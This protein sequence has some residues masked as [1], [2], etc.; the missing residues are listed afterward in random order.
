MSHLLS[1]RDFLK[2]T[3]GVL[4]TLT[5]PFDS[6]GQRRGRTWSLPLPPDDIASRAGQS[7]GRVTASRIHLHA[8]P[9]PTSEISGYRSFDELITLYSTV[10]GP[11]EMAHNT[12]WFKTE[13]GYA[14]SS[15]VQP[16][17]RQLNRPLMPSRVSEDQP[18]LLEV[19]M[20]Y[21]DV[22]RHATTTAPRVYR[23]YYATTHWAVAVERDEA[24]NSWYELRND[25]GHGHYF[26]RAEHLRPISLDELAPISPDAPDKRIE[27][28]LSAQSLTAYEGDEV[29]L[30]ARVSTGAVFSSADGA[31][32]DYRTPKGT[33]HVLR[34]RASRHMQGG[35]PGVDYFD[36]PGIPWVTYF[37][38]SGVA[39]H[40]TYW[41]NDYGRPRSHGCVNMTPEQTRWL[42]LWTE[43]A[44]PAGEE[45]LDAETETGTPI[46]VLQ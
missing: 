17:S 22:R 7:L 1:R 28:K 5:L 37:T 20:P 18:I 6:L 42:F 12:V 39:L 21:T 35:T 23:L 33:F 3:G 31:S 9:D 16:V 24:R 8:A 10:E 36:L 19:T 40:G 32:R 38:W 45:V 11:G 44:V 25:R 27:I 4:A 13:N 34:K 41:H 43:P 30:T 15:F 29:V 46:H 2:R 14:Y 26:A